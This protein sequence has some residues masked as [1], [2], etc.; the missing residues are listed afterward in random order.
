MLNY[1]IE[2]FERAIELTR[3]G[4]EADDTDELTREKL[5]NNLCYFLVES[6]A[7]NPTDLPVRKQEASDLL[8]KLRPELVSKDLLPAANFTR[9]FFEIM[10]G[11]KEEQILN[12][13][14]QCES[15]YGPEDQKPDAFVSLLIQDC[16]RF[17]WRRIL[18]L[19]ALNKSQANRGA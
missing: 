11:E 13:I 1:F 12:G 10:F 18:N 7:E 17:G 14:K 3:E 16:R 6:C 5:V 4:L 15:A 9:G 8:E 19:D 2:D